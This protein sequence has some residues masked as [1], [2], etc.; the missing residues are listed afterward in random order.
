LWIN[1]HGSWLIGLS[2]LVA[3]GVAQCCQFQAGRIEAVRPHPPVLATIW[4]V[5]TVSALALLLNPYG[6]RLVAYP[7]DLAFRQKL[8]I[9]H[10]EE[11]QSPDFHLLRGKL[12][13][14]M[15]LAMLVLMLLR[16]SRWQ[17]HEVLWVLIAWY[18]ALTYSRFMFLA[19]ILLAPIFAAELSLGRP[20]TPARD[21][22]LINA[23]FIFGLLYLAAWQIPSAA[24][25]NHELAKEYPSAAL[26]YL[27]SFQPRGPVLNDY[28]WGGYLIWNVP[29]I[30][31]FIDSRVD[32]FEY[33]GVFA[34]YLDIIGLKNSLALLE[35][36]KIRYVLFARD[37]PLT[38]LLR[39]SSEW[40]PIYNDDVAFL[41]ERSQP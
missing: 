20:R 4:S 28:D 34:D 13:L 2:V 14:A 38:Y 29:H 8:N 30:P 27:G 6:W 36:H 24:H 12:L 10:V 9:S 25:L 39:N 5:V 3:Y 18:S 41:F 33:S 31:V 23:A 7:F 19:A 17:L 1:T 35:K 37:A 21:Y 40:R 11:W 15:L 26:N 16:K 32:I 22:G